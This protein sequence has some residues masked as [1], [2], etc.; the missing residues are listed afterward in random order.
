MNEWLNPI[1]KNYRAHFGETQ[2]PNVWDVGSRD[3]RDGVELAERIFD[4]DPLYFWQR[5]SVTCVEANPEQ[6]KIIQATYPEATVLCL[7]VSDETTTSDFMVYEGN[8]GDVGSSS[9]NLEWK[10]HDNLPGHVIQVPTDRLDNLINDEEIDIM[11]IDTEGY[12]KQVLLGLG[13]KLRQVKVFHI[14]TEIDTG[15]TDWVKQYM[16][17]H[18]YLL[19]DETEQWGNMPD[20]V[21]IRQ[22][23][24]SD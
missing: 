21:F 2:R 16:R 1:I 6:A 19:V 7:A 11:K 9:L 15:S 5:A 22:T 3:G 14:E 23:V 18:N 4:G 12:S 10:K 17:E 13:D 8:E 20:L 24:Q